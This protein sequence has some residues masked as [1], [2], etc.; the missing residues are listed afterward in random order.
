MQF[1]TTLASLVSNLVPREGKALG[2]RLS[3]LTR[4][5]EMVDTNTAT[6]GQLLYELILL[7]RPESF[8]VVLYTI[9]PQFT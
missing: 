6:I 9:K 2:T 1:D 8:R 7:L 5:L 3:C 4:E